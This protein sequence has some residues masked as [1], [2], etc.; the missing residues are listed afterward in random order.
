VS[1]SRVKLE[2]RLTFFYL[3]VMQFKEL[4]DNNYLIFEDEY[5]LYKEWTQVIEA[6][7]RYID[8]MYGWIT[9]K[10]KQALNDDE[11]QFDDYSDN[12]RRQAFFLLHHQMMAYHQWLSYHP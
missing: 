12:N 6:R 8:I 7:P 11:N 3:C 2:V 10:D 5:D 9:D 4:C 1:N